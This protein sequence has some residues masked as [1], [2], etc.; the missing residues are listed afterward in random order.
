RLNEVANVYDGVENERSRAVL[1]NQQVLFLGVN[2]QPGA[3]TVA[4]VDAIKEL[5]TTFRAQLPPSMELRVVEDWTVAIRESLRDVKLTLVLTVV[6]VVIVIFLFLRNVSATLIPSLALPTSILT[7][8]AVLYLFGYSVDNLS[9]MA[10]TLS[11][12]FVVD[13]A[14]VMLEN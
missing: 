11:T 4:T 7:T 2:K 12:G 14:I 10:L 8:F 6:L 13:D 3:N 1:G 9:L 5:L